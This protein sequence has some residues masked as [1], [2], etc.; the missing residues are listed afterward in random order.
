MEQTYNV[1]AAPADSF[2]Q[3]IGQ[4]VESNL[5]NVD[6]T[7]WPTHHRWRA[8]NTALSAGLLTLIEVPEGYQVELPSEEKSSTSEEKSS[9]LTQLPEL[10]TSGGMRKAEVDITGKLQ[11]PEVK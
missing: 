10:Q 3:F 4:V 5:R 1:R 11:P 9:E 7:T 6:P 8:L 2:N